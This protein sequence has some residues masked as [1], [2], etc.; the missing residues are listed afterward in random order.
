M[1]KKKMTLE[2]HCGYPF[3]IRLFLTLFIKSKT[4]SSKDFRDLLLQ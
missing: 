2:K 1:I 3:K 4:Y